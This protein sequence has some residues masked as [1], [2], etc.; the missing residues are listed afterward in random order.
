LNSDALDAL[1]AAERRS[2]VSPVVFCTP[3]GK[4]LAG[5]FKR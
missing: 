5:D 2:I 1:R 4:S 3:E